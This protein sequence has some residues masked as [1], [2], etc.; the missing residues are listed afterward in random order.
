MITQA[1][2][3]QTIH[4][5]DIANLRAPHYRWH[6]DLKVKTKHDA[7][8]F[9]NDVGIAL[10]FPGENI[11]LPDLWSAINGHERAIPKHHHDWALGKTW[12]WKDS[13][14]T[15][16]DA[17]Y[18]K[19]IRGK[20]A[21]VALDDLPA[22]Y[23]L[24]DNY[25]ELDDY[26]E[27]YADGLMSKEAK[28]IYETLLTD[29]AMSTAQLRKATGMAGGG[30]NARRFERAITELQSSLK[31]VKSGISEDN[32]W[33]YCY[34]YDV[35]LRWAPNLAEQARGFNSRT[36]MRHIITR[37]L[38]TSVAAPPALFPRLF[39]WDPSVTNRIIEEML[40]DSTLHAVTIVAGPGLTAKA[41]PSPQ[42]DVWIKRKT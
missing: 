5:K 17:W 37:Y 12:D 31:I 33:K 8:R 7:V 42:G 19:L 14:P 36:A 4:F 39:G 26:L 10:L 13:I 18:G 6:P 25:G 22:I 29:G 3:E 11:P 35:L 32:R 27:A 23:A 16:K 24:S 30:D 40:A 38:Q 15:R 2:T 41:K 21:F 34:V 28:E 20:P 9:I 1:P